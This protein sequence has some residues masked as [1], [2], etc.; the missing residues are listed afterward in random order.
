MRKQVN[1]YFCDFCDRS[2]DEVEV[3]VV[4]KA[5]SSICGECT[6]IAM[7]IVVNYERKSPHDSENSTIS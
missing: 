6:K 3:M 5:S 4:G 2:Q 7:E 1:K